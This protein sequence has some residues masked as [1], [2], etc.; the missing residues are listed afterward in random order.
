MD[1]QNVVNRQSLEQESN[2]ESIGDNIKEMCKRYICPN[3]SKELANR[4]NLCRHKKK[5]CKGGD[6]NSASLRYNQQGEKHEQAGLTRCLEKP[7]DTTC[8]YKNLIF[9]DGYQNV[10][11]RQRSMDN[12][13]VVNRQSSEQESNVESDGESETDY[14]SS[15]KES[16]DE[17][18]LSRYISEV[19]RLYMEYRS[20]LDYINRAEDK[21]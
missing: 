8:N 9:K 19:N 14:Q 3:C 20:G 7:F 18:A 21:D 10:V 1:N 16:D 12:Q 4:H 6:P 5:Y 11:N 13:N 15:G 17:S 2:V